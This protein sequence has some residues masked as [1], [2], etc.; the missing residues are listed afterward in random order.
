M[1]ILIYPEFQKN[2][3]YRW[4]LSYDMA[5]C[6]LGE[7]SN[8]IEFEDK[9]DV[10]EWLEDQDEEFL[11]IDGINKIKQW[12]YHIIIKSAIFFFLENESEQEITNFSRHVW[13]K[14]LPYIYNV[15]FGDFFVQYFSNYKDFCVHIP[16][17]LISVIL[18]DFKSRQ[19]TLNLFNQNE[20]DDLDIKSEYLLTSQE[21]SYLLKILQLPPNLLNKLVNRYKKQE[22]FVDLINFLENYEILINEGSSKNRNFKLL[23]FLIFSSLSS[24]FIKANFYKFK[25]N[26][27][28]N[29]NGPPFATITQR[30]NFNSKGKGVYFPL[31][32]TPRPRLLV[33][34]S[35]AVLDKSEWGIKKSHIKPIK[36]LARQANSNQVRPIRAKNKPLILNLNNSFKLN[37]ENKKL[38]FETVEN[39]IKKSGIPFQETWTS[40]ET[41]YCRVKIG[42]KTYHIADN[43]KYCNI[44][45]NLLPGK[46]YLKL[47]EKAKVYA[48]IQKRELM[49]TSFGHILPASIGIV[50]KA[51]KYGPLA[52]ESGLGIPIPLY[53]NQEQG[54]LPFPDLLWKTPLQNNVTFMDIHDSYLQQDLQFFSTKLRN[55]N[56]LT[57]YGINDRWFEATLG[58]GYKQVFKIMLQENPRLRE[59]VKNHPKLSYPYFVLEQVNF[60]LTTDVI[61]LRLATIYQNCYNQ[62]KAANENGEGTPNFVKRSEIEVVTQARINTYKKYR[63]IF[64]KLETR[65][66]FLK[67]AAVYCNSLPGELM[68]PIN[69]QN[70]KLFE[71]CF[72]VLED[73]VNNYFPLQPDVQGRKLDVNQYKKLLKTMQK[74]KTEG[75]KNLIKL[76]QTVTS[77]VIANP[78]ELDNIITKIK[79]KWSFVS[80]IPGL[81]KVRSR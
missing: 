77:P 11:D 40:N 67:K 6:I 55:D 68:N 47:V 56:N 74:H 66:S 45:T 29:R 80:N 52:E 38:L 20:L 59:V 24:L 53:I 69:E 73:Q 22:N 63:K 39:E 72:L 37:S 35:P 7:T 26:I 49:Q 65:F 41:R 42:K 75:E 9:F 48:A 2:G 50:G 46:S 71:N 60:Q 44:C 27:Q 10:I 70:N 17:N 3:I 81:N 8:P 78:I 13:E 62:Q 51:G 58:S 54:R 76:T 33:K 1:N 4:P 12:P 57:I 16:E 5:F 23:I 31:G 15:E 25:N 43:G 19:N 61:R 79:N 21:I 14:L 32:S 34:R 30:P 18:T 28:L 64:E 36:D